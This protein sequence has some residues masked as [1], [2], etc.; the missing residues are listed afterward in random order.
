M[1]TPKPTAPMPA[2]PSWGLLTDPDAERLQAELEAAKAE[3]WRKEKE[4]EEHQEELTCKERERKH[5]EKDCKAMRK[6]PKI[7]A[8]IA[9]HEKEEDEVINARLSE[10]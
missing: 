9:W 1:V 10:M 3:Q 5:I 2:G 6:Q 4:E 8:E 7:D